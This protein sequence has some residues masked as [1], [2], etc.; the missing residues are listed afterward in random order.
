MSLAKFWTYFGIQNLLLGHFSLLCIA[1]ISNWSSHLV[2]LLQVKMDFVTMGMS[3]TKLI[4]GATQPFSNS[5]YF[6]ALKTKDFSLGSLVEN[7]A[8]LI[9]SIFNRSSSR[10]RKRRRK[11]RAKTSLE[12]PSSG[13]PPSRMSR[14]SRKWLWSTT[15]PSFRRWL[16]SPSRSAKSPW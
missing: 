13:W 11:K 16:T 5:W 10:K 1:K 9:S 15:S 4:D 3:I 12:F 6:M 2:T 14:W 7:G 8:K